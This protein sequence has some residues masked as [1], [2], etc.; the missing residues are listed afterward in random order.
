MNGC[1]IEITIQLYSDFMLCQLSLQN[2]PDP[3]NEHG[4]IQLSYL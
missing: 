3:R 1:V 2:I 4:D